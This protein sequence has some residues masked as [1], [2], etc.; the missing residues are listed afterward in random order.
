MA[1]VTDLPLDAKKIDAFEG[2]LK[3][4][5]TVYNGSVPTVDPVEFETHYDPDLV[6][7]GSKPG[8]PWVQTW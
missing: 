6:S 5:Q 8:K 2:I 3:N 1:R 7:L 4:C